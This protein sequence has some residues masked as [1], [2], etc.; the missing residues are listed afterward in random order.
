MVPSGGAPA[1][2]PVKTA[3]WSTSPQLGQLRAVAEYMVRTG[4]VVD[5]GP[6][7]DVDGAVFQKRD[8]SFS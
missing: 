5:G 4:Q 2:V 3:A 8:A 6:A 7:F 1:V